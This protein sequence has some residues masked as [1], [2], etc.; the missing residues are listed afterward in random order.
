M[1]KSS[2]LKC[3]SR[4]VPGGQEK[5]LL[6]WLG[7]KSG[8]GWSQCWTMPGASEGAPWPYELPDLEPIHHLGVDGTPASPL[9]WSPC[10]GS[11]TTT[12]GLAPW[13]DINSWVA[14]WLQGQAVTPG[15]QN[16]SRVGRGKAR[17]PS[18]PGCPPTSA[19]AF[20]RPPSQPL[21]QG[22]CLDPWPHIDRHPTVSEDLNTQRGPAMG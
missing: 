4:H 19:P 22:L 13:A 2:R 10:G 16:G 17:V 15:W 21:Q 9:R 6:E 5:A 11:A 8:E 20:P 7:S 12:G 18:T 14:E 3:V 1:Q